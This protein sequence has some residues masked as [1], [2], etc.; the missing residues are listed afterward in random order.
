MTHK[1]L[2]MRSD[3]S[4]FSPPLWM[5]SAMVQ[6][7]LASLKFRKRGIT[8]LERKS[9]T[10]ILV[11]PEGVRLK[12]VF[13]ES[14]DETRPVFIFIH[15][16]EGSSDSTY[17]VAAARRVYDK[18]CAVVRLNLRDHGDTHA[19]NEG[20]FYATLFDEV[21]DAVQIICERYKTRPVILAG[22]SLGGN[23]TLRVARRLS[24]SP[25]SNL[26]HLIAVSP[27]IDPP[28]SNPS[29][30]H[31]RLIRSYFLKKWKRSMQL[32]QAAFPEVYNFDHVMDMTDIMKMTEIIIPQYTDYPDAMTYFSDYALGP[33]DIKDCPVPITIIAA[34]DD[35]VV[36]MALCE[37]LKLSAQSQLYMWK[38]GGHNGFFQ[39]L[40]GPTG[41]DDVMSHII[42]GF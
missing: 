13:S 8:A 35:P 21:F 37:S 19:L 9:R 15:G 1:G 17:V 30:D 26:A 6:T 16:W 42:E 27:V 31:N 20:A 36:P 12:A 39:S 34:K 5:R 28:S 11:T 40:T 41:Y 33:Q 23:Y 10:D 22:F 18:G 24:Q 4:N 38:H 7:G 2:V 3:I 29:L 32:K 25:I 14:V